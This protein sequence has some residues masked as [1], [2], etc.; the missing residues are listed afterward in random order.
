MQ[1]ILTD[2]KGEID[3]NTI[4][5]GDF[6][7]PLTSINRPS[8]QKSNKVTEIL[9]DT[10]EKSDLIDIFRTL[11]PKKPEYTFFSSAHGTSSRTD[12][13]L[14][15]KTNLNKF[16]SR[17]VISSIFSDHND[18]KLETDHRK[19]SEKTNYMETKQPATK[20]NQWVNEEI[21]REVKR[22]LKTNDNENTTIQNLWDAP[23]AVLRGKFI[24]IQA[25]LKKKKNLKPS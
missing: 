25:F 13:I 12:P 22:C 23:K 4:I 8:T 20:K 19:R 5:V 18:T 10:I 24:A 7:T 17:E 2:I 16:K 1:Q 9:N 11:H 6:N 3:G 15:H 21:K 14:G